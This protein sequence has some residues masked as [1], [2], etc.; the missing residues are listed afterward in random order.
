MPS[1]NPHVMIRTRPPLLGSRF[2]STFRL[3]HASLMW[4]DWTGE[5]VIRG[6]TNLLH[7]VFLTLMAEIS[8]RTGQALRA[9]GIPF[10]FTHEGRTAYSDR[11]IN[12]FMISLVPP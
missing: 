9:I 5:A 2:V 10:R 11:A 7:H 3:R 12:S 8:A 1:S 6:E 4:S